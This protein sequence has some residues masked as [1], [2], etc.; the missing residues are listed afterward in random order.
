LIWRVIG[1]W[2]DSSFAIGHSPLAILA[3]IPGRLPEAV[4]HFEAALRITP[5]AIEA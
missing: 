3:N 5:D 4:S 2:R 1:G